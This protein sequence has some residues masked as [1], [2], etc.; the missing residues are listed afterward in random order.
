M[1]LRVARI[2]A[3]IPPLLGLA[4]AVAWPVSHWRWVALNLNGQLS[5]SLEPGGLRLAYS[6]GGSF[7][8][9][10]QYHFGLAAQDDKPMSIWRDADGMHALGFGWVWSS[11]WP[12][13]VR[14]GPGWN[15]VVIVDRFYAITV[16]F[17]FMLPVCM[18][19]MIPWIKRHR[20]ADPLGRPCEQC[21]YD[22]RA[23]PQQCPECGRIPT[24][25]SELKLTSDV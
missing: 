2:L 10:F 8:S 19:L 20:R 25:S 4:M 1:K 15:Y 16:P 24:Q 6:P 13:S 3:V 22:L 14:A 5:I 17:W 11:T 23:T 9:G 12:L 21:G 18:L 7:F